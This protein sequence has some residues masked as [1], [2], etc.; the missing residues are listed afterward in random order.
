M[1]NSQSPKKTVLIVDDQTPFVLSLSTGLKA[2]NPKYDILTAENGKCAMEILESKR[3]DLVLTDLRMPEMDGFELLAFMSKN[4]PSIPVIVMSAYGTQEIKDSLDN[5]GTLKF[6]EKPVDFQ[7]LTNTINNGL[8]LKQERGG[9]LHGISIPSFLQL[10]E[11]EKKTCMLDIQGEHSDLKGNFYFNKGEL[12]DAVFG[13]LHGEE[14]AK[15]IIGWE[16]AEIKFNELPKKKINKRINNQLM[17][18]IMEALRLKDE[19]ATEEQDDLEALKHHYQKKA[20]GNPPPRA[21][22]RQDGIDNENH[23]I[24]ESEK[25]TSMNVK[26]INDTVEILKDDL[27]DGLLAADIFGTSDGQTIAGYNTQPKAAALFSQLTKYMNKSLENSGFPRL[28]KYYF[29]DLADDKMIFLIPL[30]DFL[31]GILINK[32]KVQLGLMLNVILPK[33]IDSFEDAIVG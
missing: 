26:K 2:I 10:I 30:G 3:V 31:W 6:L 7:E 28:G 32:E 27:G 22:T 20:S 14:A 13:D 25:E 24:I 8:H 16:N 1:E 17:A 5:M 12:F 33:I 18:L 9:F 4:Y 11:M 21:D 15:K 19:T 23:K 29:L